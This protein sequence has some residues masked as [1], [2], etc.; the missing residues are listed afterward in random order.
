MT[1]RRV[2]VNGLAFGLRDLILG[3]VVASVGFYLQIDW[4]AVLGLTGLAVGIAESQLY[5]MYIA[6]DEVVVSTIRGD[7]SMGLNEIS[8]VVEERSILSFLGRKYV[9]V[10]ARGRRM[11]IVGVRE[12]LITLLQS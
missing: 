12:D 4:L 2:K 11:P 5:R 6:D 7:T 8:E 10:D 3:T 9:L 1:W